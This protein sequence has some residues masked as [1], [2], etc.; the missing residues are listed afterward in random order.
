M[1][2]QKQE[3]YTI[4]EN[5][6]EELTPKI[7]DYVEYL[8]FSYVM[9]NAPENLIIKDQKDLIEKLEKGMQDT[10]NGKVC[11]IEDAF[12]EVKEILAN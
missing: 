8:R 10:K 11:S 3:L 9:K 7:I 5:L 4:I 6:P 12:E 2:A 1:S